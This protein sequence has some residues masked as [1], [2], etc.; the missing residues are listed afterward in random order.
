MTWLTGFPE[1]DSSKGVASFP[2]SN[3]LSPLETPL[4]SP[5]LQPLLHLGNGPDVGCDLLGDCGQVGILLLQLKK[6]AEL[7]CG[8]QCQSVGSC[9]L[10]VLTLKPGTI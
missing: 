1:R 8:G 5:G 2:H 4:A 3:V 7:G 10:Q 9:W 6:V